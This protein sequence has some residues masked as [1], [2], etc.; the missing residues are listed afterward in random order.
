MG[1]IIL[2]TAITVAVVVA[3][4]ELA[5]RQTWVAGLLA[6]L[7]FTSLL[8]LTWTFL[9]TRDPVRVARLSLDIFWMV[10]PTLF[11]FLLLPLLLRLKV[12]YPLAL[13]LSALVLAG[14]YPVYVNVLSRLKLLG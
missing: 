5:R 6:A 2:K 13:A 4:S 7:P 14:I 8:A 1:Y 3:V 9:D 10:L 12:G 11:F